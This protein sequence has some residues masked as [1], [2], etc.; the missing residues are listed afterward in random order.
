MK[1][2]KWYG[3]KQKPVR[4]GVYITYLVNAEYLGY[5]YWDG[6]KWSDTREDKKHCTS[7]TATGMQRKMWRGVTK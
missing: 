4:E 1:L 6:E 3:Y 5:S 7:K 2:T